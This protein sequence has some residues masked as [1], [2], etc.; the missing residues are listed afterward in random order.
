M[1]G[2]AGRKR[3]LGTRYASGDLVPQ[4]RL[5]RDLIAAMQPHRQWLPENLRSHPKAESYFGQLNLM[6]ALT[7]DQYEA[8]RRFAQVVMNY[9]TVIGAPKANP[10][11]VSGDNVRGRGELDEEECVARKVAYE[12]AI[13]SFAKVEVDGVKSPGNS[14]LAMKAV[15]RVA[16]HNEDCPT[17]VDYLL[18]GLDNLARH[19]GIKTNIVPFVLTGKPAFEAGRVLAY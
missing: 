1:A 12:W 13:E 17:S 8:G 16:V 14:Q 10:S 5:S 15:S 4:P 7:D 11:S 19:F 6:G 9:R 2:R 3:K 18:A